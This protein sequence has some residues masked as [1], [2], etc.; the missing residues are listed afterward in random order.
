MS[1]RRVASRWLRAPGIS[2]RQGVLRGCRVL[3]GSVVEDGPVWAW[4]VGHV[5]AVCDSREAGEAE[6][7]R[8]LRADGWELLDGWEVDGGA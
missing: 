5:S 6:V 8:R 1:P 3:L 4:T 2:H 7:D